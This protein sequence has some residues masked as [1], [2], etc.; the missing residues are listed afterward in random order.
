MISVQL[1]R[2]ALNERIDGIVRFIDATHPSNGG[3]SSPAA[4]SRE[5]RGLSIVLLFAA[6]ENLLTSLTRTLLEGAIAVRVGNGRL[7][8]GFRAF[9]LMSAAKSVR[10]SSEKK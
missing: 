2:D 9:A 4:V 8:P 5:A 6:Y 7:Q 10:D 1:H 3:G